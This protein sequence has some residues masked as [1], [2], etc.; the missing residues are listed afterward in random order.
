MPLRVVR[1]EMRIAILLCTKE[2]VVALVTMEV[3]KCSVLVTILAVNG[4]L[5]VHKIH[6]AR[7]LLMLLLEVICDS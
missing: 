7:D 6:R 4:S 5:I 1:L 3:K 2:Q